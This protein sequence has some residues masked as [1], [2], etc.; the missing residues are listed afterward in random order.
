MAKDVA[1]ARSIK[2]TDD[3]WAR[4]QI[5]AKVEGVSVT[6]L[7]I[8]RMGDPGDVVSLK[9][10]SEPFVIRDDSE[11]KDAVIKALTIK[12]E[13]LERGI[14]QGLGRSSDVDLVRGS[15]SHG[16]GKA[17]PGLDLGRSPQ[18]SALA[19]MPVMT[20]FPKRELNPRVLAPKPKVKR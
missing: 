12:V 9:S 7:I 10:P 11:A 2:V 5:E 4:W 18:P 15:V 8:R 17:R 19:S 3:V 20:D 13:R 16:Q 14:A 1:K 6:A